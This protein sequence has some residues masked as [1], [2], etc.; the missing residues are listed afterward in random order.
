MTEL[1]DDYLETIPKT[2]GGALAYHT[3]SYKPGDYNRSEMVRLHDYFKES[4]YMY[5]KSIWRPPRESGLTPKIT[6]ARVI[7]YAIIQSPQW[8]SELTHSSS[9]ASIYFC[10]TLYKKE[11]YFEFFLELRLV[12]D[13]INGINF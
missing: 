1:P 7:R 10:V 12:E 4:M 9:V 2:L 8:F 6:K 3:I 5:F 13:E 11:I